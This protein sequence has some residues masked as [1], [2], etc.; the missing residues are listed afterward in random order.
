LSVASLAKGGENDERRIDAL[1]AKMTI[2]EKFGQLQQLGGDAKSGGLR[3]GQGELV[4]RGQIGS[5]IDV[6][7][8]RKS[9]EVQRLAIESGPS[10]I[11]A[12]FGYDVIHGYRTIFA[13][14]PS[15][16]SGGAG[17]SRPCDG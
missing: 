7:G 4:R 16:S 9:N 17:R 8:A 12:L 1:L 13:V 15:R 3:E 11:P 2:E 5:F 14:P 10:K 6:R